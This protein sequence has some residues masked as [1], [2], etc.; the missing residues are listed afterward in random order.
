MS[1]ALSGN[2]ESRQGYICHCGAGSYVESGGD[3]A[4]EHLERSILRHL[5][6]GH[7]LRMVTKTEY[8]DHFGTPH[9]PP[10]VSA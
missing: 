6:W 8:E 5:R 1:D 3:L 9:K 7:I 4:V 10:K 2:S